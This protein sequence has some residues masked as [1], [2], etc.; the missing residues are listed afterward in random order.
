M[1]R[2]DPDL[3]WLRRDAGRG[4]ISVPAWEAGAI[5]KHTRY[6]AVNLAPHGISVRAVSL[7]MVETEALQHFEAAR[8]Q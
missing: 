3:G 8:Q 1:N 2:Q 5:E 7:G 6:L 4:F